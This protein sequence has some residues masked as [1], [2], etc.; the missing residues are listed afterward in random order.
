MKEMND[1]DRNPHLGPTH[2]HKGNSGTDYPAQYFVP[3]HKKSNVG[4][5]LIALLYLLVGAVMLGLVLEI[6]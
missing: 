3:L 1:S 6:F 4:V 2:W 5:A